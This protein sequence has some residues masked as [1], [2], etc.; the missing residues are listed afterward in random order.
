MSLPYPL[1]RN[2]RQ[3]RT[4]DTFIRPEPLYELADGSV[5]LQRNT[6]QDLTGSQFAAVEALY[7]LGP[8]SQGEISG[9]VLKSGSNM[10]TVIDHLE[11]DGLVRREHRRE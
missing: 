2:P 4:L 6:F 11:R 5:W 1:R 10:T 8:M 9:K 7:H 3:L